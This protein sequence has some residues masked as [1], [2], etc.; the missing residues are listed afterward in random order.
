MADRIQLIGVNSRPD[1]QLAGSRRY[2][3]F[4]TLDDGK[5]EAITTFN[6]LDEMHD[7]MADETYSKDP[8]LR[9]T[10]KA[11]AERSIAAGISG[12]ADAG[13]KKGPL[14]TSN[15]EMLA[16]M[17]REMLI[18]Q[19]TKIQAKLASTS[20]TERYEAAVWLADPTNAAL[21]AEAEQIVGRTDGLQPGS[22]GAF[23]KDN[24][25]TVVT[26]PTEDP[27]NVVPSM[28]DNAENGADAMIRL[29]L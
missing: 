19:N 28:S 1:A 26:T 8:I 6:S 10:I 16:S 29:N 11:I 25:P 4:R 18:E 27:A 17:R 20:A 24:G 5:E 9:E 12:F 7:F 15:A 2:K 21:I 22:L 13:T 23:I 3:L 14:G